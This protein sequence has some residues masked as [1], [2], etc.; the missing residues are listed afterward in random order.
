[1]CKSIQ[2]RSTVLDIPVCMSK[3]DTRT[4]TSEDSEMQILWAHIIRGWMQNKDELE[5][6]L[7]GYW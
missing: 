4:A 7:G 1:M 2:T 3:E 6:S 5:P